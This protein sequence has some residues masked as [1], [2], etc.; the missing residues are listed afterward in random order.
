MAPEGNGCYISPVT[1]DLPKVSAIGKDVARMLR[2]LARTSK[3]RHL[4]AENNEALRLMRRDLRRQVDAVFR[5]VPD[6]SLVIRP[7]AIVFS[8][9]E[10]YADEVGESD[11]LPFVLY[12]DGLRKIV[13]QEGIT[14]GELDALAE[15]I[16]Q[17]QSGRSFEDD[18]VT[19]LW[20]YGYEHVRYVT[21]DVHVTDAGSGYDG[22]VTDHDVSLDQQVEA[23]LRSLYRPTTGQV[24]FRGL[25]IDEYDEAAKAIADA[26]GEIDEMAPGHHPSSTLASLP[27]YSGRLKDLVL[28]SELNLRFVEEA[29]NAVTAAPDEAPPILSSLLVVLDGAL[30]EGQL[31]LASHLVT[32]IRRLPMS[33]EVETWLG[34]ALS[35]ARLRQVAGL[36]QSEPAL[37][38][39]VFEFFEACG[40]RAIPPL[41]RSIPALT[42]P[43]VRRRISDLVL[44]L[45]QPEIGLVRELVGHEQGFAAREGLYMLARLDQLGDRHLLR[46]VHRH[47]NPQVRLAL[48]QEIDRVPDDVASWVL[49]ELVRDDASRVRVAAVETL[50]Q[51]GGEIACRTLLHTL[52]RPDFDDEADSFKKA[53]MA[54]LVSAMGTGALG[55]LRA[56]MERAD[57]WMVRGSI[58][59]TALAA[60]QVVGQLRHQAAVDVLKAAT[61]LKNRTIRAEARRRLERMREGSA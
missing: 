51:L 42:Q 12:R 5:Q 10:V 14:D 19:R 24:T 49:A 23:L 20:Q 3:S 39:E 37:S 30:V 47:P 32:R 6:V 16:Y 44:A 45:G 27:A 35:D 48:I 61:S 17:G 53:V 31:N 43:E 26:M 4:Y 56:L 22:A 55:R 9:E 29:L 36:L 33:P 60:V 11:S 18:V 2:A 25:N 34:E 1:V 41:L 54:G 57:G 40:R 58:E 21:V 7:D 8:D 52:D 15:A 50:A 28:G 59:S 13:L 46:D 38:T